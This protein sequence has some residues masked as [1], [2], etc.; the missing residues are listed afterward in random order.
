MIWLKSR[1]ASGVMP[2]DTLNVLK[3]LKRQDI[4]A[5]DADSCRSWQAHPV[6][7]QSRSDS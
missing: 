7:R 4:G 3:A 6:T 1:L 2:V 5:I